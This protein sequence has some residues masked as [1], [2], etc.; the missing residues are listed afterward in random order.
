[1]K[2]IKCQQDLLATVAFTNI[3]MEATEGIGQKYKKGAT[4]DCFFLMVGYP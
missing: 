1:M 2:H 4:K 3:I